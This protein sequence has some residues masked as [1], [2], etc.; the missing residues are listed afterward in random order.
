MEEKREYSS[1]DWF[2]AATNEDIINTAIR[3]A[4]ENIVNTSYIARITAVNENT[5]DVELL[6]GDKL[7]NVPVCATAFNGWTISLPLK[8]QD[9][10]IVIFMKYEI[11]DY[12]STGEFAGDSLSPFSQNNGLF[13]PFALFNQPKISDDIII[14]NEKINLTIN[15][16]NEV[17]FSDEKDSGTLSINLN[18][19]NEIEIDNEK[20][21]VLIDKDGGF[22][23]KNDKGSCS[24]DK[25]GV[26]TLS[27]DGG[28]ITMDAQGNITIKGSKAVID[29]DNIEL[30]KG[31]TEKLVLGNK[32]LQ[33][34]NKLLTTISTHTHLVETKGSAVAQSGTAAPSTD[35]TSLTLAS[36][37]LSTQNASK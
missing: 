20:A 26:F 35:L 18:K 31:A 27:N 24:V 16:D 15:A 14:T 1:F 28:E 12:K 6:N 11:S 10:G 17:L 2:D 4:V 9:T 23:F 19:D 8:E 32:M 21:T 25:D 22:S 13:I 36:S 34:M 5:V 37:I 33:E 30:G 3:Q 29:A 7:I